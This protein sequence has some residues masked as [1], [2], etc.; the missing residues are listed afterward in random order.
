M[1]R[2][3]V[4]GLLTMIA[5]FYTLDR[6]V[7]YVTQELVKIEF[8]L[9]D[10]QVG[11]VSGLAFGLANGLTAIPMGWLSDRMNRAKLLSFCIIIWSGMTALC[12]APFNFV[13]LV[14]ARVA[15]GAAESG[16]TP[17][18]MS[19]LTDLYD[20]DRRGS[21]M[22]ILSAGYGAGT[23]LSA[24]VGSHVAATYG[25]RAVF[26]LYGLPGVLLGFLML[27]T[28]REPPRNLPPTHTHVSAKSIPGA[29]W[30]LLTQPGLRVIYLG[31]ALSSMISSGVASWWAS[32]MMRVHHME[33]T[34]V[35]IVSTMSLG[36]CSMLGML[37]A[38][39]AADWAR[40][41]HPGGALIVMGVATVINLMSATL[42]IWTPNA[43]AM[44]FA[45]CI[46]GA[47]VSAYL[48]PRGAALSEF[49]PI[50]LRGIA[51]TLPIVITS[52]IGN[53]IGSITIG[54]ISDV[55][56]TTVH[57]VEP[58]RIAMFSVILLQIPVAAMYFTSATH[59]TRRMNFL[60]A[61]RI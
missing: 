55:A 29:I 47:T 4:L 53:A 3:Y 25:W 61:G 43:A 26:L 13:Y 52:L 49:A 31:T 44:I 41:R 6:N 50:H 8:K 10:T 2:N 18:S 48:A 51:F 21:K 42:A 46:F 15:V 22:G 54:I 38:G 17:I 58:L 28:L 59:M 5:C 39:Y 12:A 60:A 9:S 30:H 16:G 20:A 19:L 1:Y 32:F 27:A 24:L 7:L 37:G 11:L 33:I 34:T 40:R 35:G 23:I 57:E 56:T 36:V 45:L 14:L